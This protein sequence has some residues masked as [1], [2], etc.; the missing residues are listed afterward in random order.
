MNSWN[1]WDSWKPN[2]KKPARKNHGKSGEPEW[3]FTR[4][5]WKQRGRQRLPLRNLSVSQKNLSRLNVSTEGQMTLRKEEQDIYMEMQSAYY[6]CSIGILAKDLREG[7]P[8]PVCGSTKHPKPAGIPSEAPDREQLEAQKDRAEKAEEL[9]R[10]WYEKMLKLKE[11]KNTAQTEWK[12]KQEELGEEPEYEGIT[13]EEACSAE[14]FYQTKKKR[15]VLADVGA[16]DEGRRP[17][18]SV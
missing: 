17:D 18:E 13:R 8:C 2:M 4:N 12:R 1:D 16:A 15:T 10:K 14:K 7:K 6:A 11:Q 5:G 9:F 3:Q